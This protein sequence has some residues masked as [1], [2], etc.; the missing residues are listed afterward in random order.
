M[1]FQLAANDINIHGIP[2]KRY[3]GSSIFR[4]KIRKNHLARIYSISGI[5]RRGL[6]MLPGIEPPLL[7]IFGVEFYALMKAQNFTLFS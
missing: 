1:R 3:F 7:L 4:P 2:E 6:K 5:S